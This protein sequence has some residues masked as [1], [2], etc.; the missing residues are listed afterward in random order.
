LGGARREGFPRALRLKTRREFLH[1]QDKGVKVSA[2]PLLGVAL[3]NG[4]EMTRLG[5]TVSSKVGNAVERA[6][7]RRCLR[8]LFRKR[9]GTLPHG[10]DVVLIARQS[11]RQADFETFGRAFEDITV[12][13]RGAFA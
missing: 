7:I 1:V 6:R 2:G 10:L 13:L 5:L 3:R 9:R 8:E 11:A 12:R 4:R